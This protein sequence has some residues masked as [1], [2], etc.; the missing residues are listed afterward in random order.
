MKANV[1]GVLKKSEYYFSSPS[2][3]A[4]KLYYY[5]VSAGHFYCDNRYHLKRDDYN[6]IL[7][8]HIINGS[9]TFVA[10]GIQY[11]AKAGETV[12]LDC[13]KPH[14]YYTLDTLE[15]VWLH[16]NG[17]N[18]TDMYDEVVKADGSIISCSD[19]YRTRD[20][21]FRIYNS[22]STDDKPSEFSLSM[23][24]YELFGQL[25]NPIKPGKTNYE[26]SIHEAKKYIHENVGSEITV[27]SIAEYIHMSP[28]H[29]SNIFKKQ[30]GLSPY[31]YVL[32]TRLNHAK[33]Y[34]Q[35]SDMNISEIA[36]KVGFNSESNFI[37]FFT[38]NT[39]ISPSKFRKIVV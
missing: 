22:I 27:K 11:T 2:S 12:I 36:E 38:K 26:I 1:P 32:I 30:T 37:Y 4:Q 25:L 23:L 3:T 9:F 19:P 15:Y 29:F 10:D 13:H 39:G 34:L 14:E 28:S 16:F 21:L 33:N 17:L 20:L 8:A 24:I 35:K 5:P 31:D 6:S 18:V 7:I